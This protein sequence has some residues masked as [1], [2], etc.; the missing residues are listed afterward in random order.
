M[1][2]KANTGWIA[3][4]SPYLIKVLLLFLLLLTLSAAWRWTPLS[5]WVSVERIIDWQQS[6]RNHPGAFYVV[7]GVYLLA[8][9]ILFPVTILNLATVVTFGPAVGNVYALAGWLASAAM[10]YGIGRAAG[11]K[12]VQKLAG[13]WLPQLTPLAG[14]RG[15]FTVL[16]LRIFPIAPF[17]LVNL[18]VG[19]SGICV[20]DFFLASLIGRIPGILMLTLAGMQIENA[21]SRPALITCVVLG[22]IL[23]LSPIATSWF[24]KRLRSATRPR[25]KVVRP[26]R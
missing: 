8:G 20:W 15:F 17:T 2:D 5:E 23:I 25:R 10:G 6:V 16:T 22:L 13:S 26:M 12:P 24:L 11:R 4:R 14:G 18:F 19:A 1:K 21:L 9:L 3:V 7:V